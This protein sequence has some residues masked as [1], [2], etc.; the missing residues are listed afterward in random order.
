MCYGC[1]TNECCNNNT[2]CFLPLSLCRDTQ[3][4]VRAQHDDDGR[5]RSPGR[6]YIHNTHTLDTKPNIKPPHTNPHMHVQPQTQRKH[7]DAMNRTRCWS[8]QDAHSTQVYRIHNT[9]H[10]AT[11]HTRHTTHGL[12]RLR[13]TRWHRR[14]HGQRQMRPTHS[15]Q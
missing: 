15:E 4:S 11:K 2:R 14:G 10:L 5:R 8:S 3:D 7:N 1:V 12:T 13:R 9:I 6:D